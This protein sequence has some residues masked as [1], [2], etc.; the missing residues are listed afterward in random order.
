AVVADAGR[1]DD[2]T[3]TDLTAARGREY[4]GVIAAPETRH[5]LADQEPRAEYPRLLVRLSRQLRSTDATGESQVVPD[6]RARSRLA[7]HRRALDHDRLEAFG[8]AVHR[9]GQARDPPPDDPPL[10]PP[11]S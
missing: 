9:P 3:R 4:V 6:H 7:T 10:Q 1:E 8:R 11:A 2:G 5:L